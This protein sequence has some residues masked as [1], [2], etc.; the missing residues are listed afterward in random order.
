MRRNKRADTGPE[1]SVRRELHRRGLRFRKDLPLRLPGTTVRPDV[2]FTRARVAV[3]IDGCFWHCC[4]LHLTRPRANSWYWGPKLEANVT[5]DR[6]IDSLL[7]EAG[8]AVLRS[9][10]HEDPSDVADRVIEALRERQVAAARVTKIVAVPHRAG[11]AMSTGA[12][13]CT[14]IGQRK[15]HHFRRAAT[16]P[17]KAA[18]PGGGPEGPLFSG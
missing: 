5:R 7:S 17:S 13:K 6:L 12:E 18:R 16:L 8:W 11:G 9:W 1:L 2:V 14:R 10:E 3:F 4:P 15:V